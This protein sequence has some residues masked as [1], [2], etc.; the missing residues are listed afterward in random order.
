M[1]D[2]TK[3]FWTAMNKYAPQWMAGGSKYGQQAL[4]LCS[5]WDASMAF[6]KAIENAAV[7]ATATATTQDVI[8]GLSMFKGETLDGY[9]PP[10]TFSDGTTPN[11]Q[12]K[13]IFTYKWSGTTMIRLPKDDSSTC[14]P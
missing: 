3:D 11:P 8:K 5:T 2:G 6:K 12:Q 9:A 14:Q 1:K 10:L 7:A 4:V 13:C